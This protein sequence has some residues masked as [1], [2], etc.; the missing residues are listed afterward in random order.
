M[1][2]S[3]SARRR[4]AAVAA[5]LPWVVWAALR[6]SGTER[7][8][9]LV[10][11]LTFTPHV[12]ATA[13]VPLGIALR[14]RSR[15]GVL[16]S[17]GAGTA[18]AAAVLSRR[19]ARTAVPH[20]GDRLRIATVSLRVGLVAAEP[21]LELVRR[22]DVD[23]VAVQE[24]TP[25]SEHRL[26]AAGLDALLPHSHVLPARPGSP[27]SASGA[28]WSRRPLRAHGAV[29]GGFEQPVVLLP[30]DGVGGPAVEVTAVHIWPP[31]ISPAWVRQWA[32]DLA[33][34]PA[35]EPGV[36]RVL[37]GDFNASL[38]HGALRRVLRL[39][40]TDAA[41]AVGRALTWTWAPMR[42]RFPRLAIDHVLIDPR[43]AVASVDVLPLRGSDHR[44]VVA[45]LVLP[46]P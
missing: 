22:H 3:P 8:F 23:V 41:Q 5:A 40:Y 28:V 6:S 45:E 33:A 21:V 1:A 18:L 31:S 15:A 11:A 29:P 36:L 27:P 30:A 9:P 25:N 26:R 2:A 32:A 37:A 38:D 46:S 24:L 19:G 12:A 10:P 34:L 13:V 16:L 43:I 39:G 42:F 17:A 4:T 44:A 7:G 35:P 20:D 14:L